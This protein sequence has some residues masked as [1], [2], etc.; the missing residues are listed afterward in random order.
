MFSALPIGE[1]TPTGASAETKIL[2][3]YVPLPT[4]VGLVIVMLSNLNVES[5][6]KILS[7]IYRRRVS[8]YTLFRS[9]QNIMMYWII[10]EV[11]CGVYYPER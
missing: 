8:F 11:N 6:S 7:I 4:D 3:K 2:L 1:L 10:N 9:M 5:V